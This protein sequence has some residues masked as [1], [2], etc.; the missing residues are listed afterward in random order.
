MKLAKHGLFRYEIRPQARTGTRDCPGTGNWYKQELVQETALVRAT[1]TGK[2][3]QAGRQAGWLFGRSVGWLG[4]FT[5]GPHYQGKRKT[6]SRKW[7]GYN[8]TTKIKRVCNHPIFEA[9]PRSPCSGDLVGTHPL[10]S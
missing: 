6:W 7:K 3:W 5:A 4:H 1:G 8:E 9:Q 10:G 2:N